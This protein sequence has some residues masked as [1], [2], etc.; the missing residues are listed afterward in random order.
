M[1]PLPVCVHCKSAKEFQSIRLGRAKGG[2]KVG[3]GFR[4]TAGRGEGRRGRG[5]WYSIRS[6]LAY[7]FHSPTGKTQLIPSYCLL[8]LWWMTLHVLYNGMWGV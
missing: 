8:G 4:V 7:L 1:N 2:V 3:L 5:L 6:I